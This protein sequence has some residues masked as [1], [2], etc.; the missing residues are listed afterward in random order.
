MFSR[1]VQIFEWLIPKAKE[2]ST[3]CRLN[4]T[5]LFSEL[6]LFGQIL[7]NWIHNSFFFSCVNTQILHLVEIFFTSE[8][9][10]AKEYII[11]KKKN[12]FVFRESSRY[13]NL[14]LVHGTRCRDVF[15]KK[16]FINSYLKKNAQFVGRYLYLPRH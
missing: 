11:C 3:V 2:T 10:G 9:R 5:I 13:E 8:R 15:D 6:R 14:K 12:R 16:Y 7:P 1:P 4:I